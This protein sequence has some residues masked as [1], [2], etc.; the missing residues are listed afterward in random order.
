LKERSLWSVAI[1]SPTAET[2]WKFQCG[3]QVIEKVSSGNLFGAE[4]LDVG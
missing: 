4:H 3:G 1:E 2:A